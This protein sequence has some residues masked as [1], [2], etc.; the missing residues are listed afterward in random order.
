MLRQMVNLLVDL[1]VV[2][3]VFLVHNKNMHFGNFVLADLA[4]WLR[5][6]GHERRTILAE[7]QAKIMRR[8]QIAA[9]DALRSASW[10][11]Q[12]SART[13][14]RSRSYNYQSRLNPSLSGPLKTDWIRAKAPADEVNHFAHTCNRV[15]APYEREKAIWETS[16]KNYID[17]YLHSGTNNTQVVTLAPSVTHNPLLDLGFCVWRDKCSISANVTL[18]SQ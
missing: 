9:L 6:A 1:S 14:G 12:K 3:N 11:R 8:M 4:N 17:T 7:T 16:G 10:S 5:Q 13:F 2:R 18:A 15:F